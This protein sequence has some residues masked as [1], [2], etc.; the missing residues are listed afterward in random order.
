VISTWKLKAAEMTAKIYNC[1]A[2]DCGTGEGRPMKLTWTT[3]KPT[4]PGWYWF[5]DSWVGPYIVW[6]YWADSSKK[7]LIAHGREDYSVS[8]RYGQ[9]AGPIPEPEGGAGKSG[10]TLEAYTES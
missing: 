1:V 10:E 5:Q 4:E 2:Y 6:I 9:W 7:D 8:V 3:D